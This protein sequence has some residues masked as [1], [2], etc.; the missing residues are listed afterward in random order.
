V[1]GK[2]WKR[3]RATLLTRKQTAELY[4]RLGNALAGKPEPD[5]NGP[6]PRPSKAPSSSPRDSQRDLAALGRHSPHY[7]NDSAGAQDVFAPG[8]QAE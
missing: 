4:S 5:M 3:P 1:T 6:P 8:G 7:Q 2:S